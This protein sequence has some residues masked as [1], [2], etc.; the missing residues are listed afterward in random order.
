M[1]GGIVC[2]LASISQAWIVSTTKGLLT[3]ATIWVM[4]VLSMDAGERYTGMRWPRP[5]K[6]SSARTGGL[7]ALV[8]IS[9]ACGVTAGG[10]DALRALPEWSLAYPGSEQVTSGGGDAK[11]TVDGPQSAFTWRWLGVDASPEEIEHFYADALAGQGWAD[12]G[13][14]SGISTTG[15][16]SARAWHKDA[17]VFRLG[18]LNPEQRANAKALSRYRTVYDARL[19]GE[20]VDG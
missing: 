19:I 2:R 4:D 9:A 15:E 14:S 16:F 18:F 20:A 8:V 12:G 13:G 11:M 1:R 10:L 6:S 7:L 3:P 17:V 5:W